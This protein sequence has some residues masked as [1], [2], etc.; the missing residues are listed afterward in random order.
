MKHRNKGQLILNFFL[1]LAQKM[2]YRLMAQPVYYAQTVSE[3]YVLILTKDHSKN[4]F[5]RF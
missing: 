2:K 4:N 3:L 5:P 1:Y